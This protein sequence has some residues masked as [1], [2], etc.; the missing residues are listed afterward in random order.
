[1]RTKEVTHTLRVFAQLADFERSEELLRL[2]DFVDRGKNETLV[3]RLKHLS[4]SASYPSRMKGSLELI[5][6][7]LRFAGARRQA[8]EICAVLKLFKGRAGASTAEFLAQISKPPQKPIISLRGYRPVDLD[9]VNRIVEQ[10]KDLAHDPGV[11]RNILAELSSPYRV[12]TVALIA[13]A[14]R[15]LENDCIY[16]DR[17]TAIR[18]IAR[19]VTVQALDLKPAQDRESMRNK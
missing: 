9:L 11:F 16:R 18:A 15:Y 7:G 1:M 14:N 17:M 3:E 10:L 19:E 13:I 6:S 8:G 5:E 2:A 12:P 4:P